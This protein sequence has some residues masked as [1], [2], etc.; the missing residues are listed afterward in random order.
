MSTP[1]RRLGEALGLTVL[2]EVGDD[3]AVVGAGQGLGQR[4][5]VRLAAA[6][7][8]EGRAGGG[9]ALWR[10]PDRGRRWPR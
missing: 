7:E 8:D 3:D 2:G 1:A 5:Q 4:Q 6:A 9:E 10:S